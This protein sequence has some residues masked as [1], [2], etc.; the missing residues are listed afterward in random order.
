MKKIAFLFVAI[1]FY[2]NV[3]YAQDDSRVYFNMGFKIGTNLSNVYDAQGESFEADS[4]FGSVIGGFMRIPFGSFLGFQPEILFSQKGFQ[5]TGKVLGLAYKYSRR[6]NYIDI[7]LM[8]AIKPS[9]NIT[10]VG[11]PQYS[12]LLKQTDDFSTPFTSS[13]TVEEF[14]NEDINK[15]ILCFIGGGDINLKHL[16]LGG[17]VGWDIT[18]NN[19]DGTS[20]IP[21][22]KN[23]WYQAT[24]GH[25]F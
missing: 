16:V 7:P 6:T 21:R 24:I 14:K 11:G 1:S 13:E 8:I 23:V 9:P 22:Y 25:V 20:T 3:S 4:R 10:I 2:I 5:G 15:N 18:R 12:Y 17:R 19:G